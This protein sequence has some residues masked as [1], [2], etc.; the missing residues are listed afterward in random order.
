MKVTISLDND[1]YFPSE[2]VPSH[3]KL[4]LRTQVIHPVDF[5]WRSDDLCTLTLSFH[6]PQLFQGQT[7]TSHCNIRK[8]TLQTRQ[9]EVDDEGE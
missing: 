1:Q 2:N 6:N 5:F 7:R 8:V 9:G 4:C 3:S